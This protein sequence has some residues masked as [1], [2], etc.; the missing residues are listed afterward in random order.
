[1]A[2]SAGFLSSLIAPPGCDCDIIPRVDASRVNQRDERIVCLLL[3]SGCAPDEANNLSIPAVRNRT[4]A[5]RTRKLKKAAERGVFVFIVGICGD[6]TQT[7]RPL[8]T[9]PSCET[10]N[11]SL[12]FS[13]NYP[14]V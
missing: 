8:I 11:V 14:L 12:S 4:D 13:G 10:P 3:L 6:E 2:A 5:A 9:H 1:C 7:G